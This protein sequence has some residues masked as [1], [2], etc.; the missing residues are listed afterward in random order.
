VFLLVRVTK[1]DKNKETD[2]IVRVSELS[3]SL[4]ERRQ[5]RTSLRPAQLPVKTAQFTQFFR[6]V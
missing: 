6:Q 3:S 4:C 2:E 5:E 1:M